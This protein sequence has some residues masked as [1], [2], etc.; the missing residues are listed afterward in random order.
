MCKMIGNLMTFTLFVFVFKIDVSWPDLTLARKVR[1]LE[2]SRTR[3]SVFPRLGR[4]T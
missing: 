3:T 4:T 2:A 1:H